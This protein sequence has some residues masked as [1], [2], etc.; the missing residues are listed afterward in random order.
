MIA[1]QV[2]VSRFVGW[3]PASGSAL[4]AWSLRGMLSLPLSAP[5]PLACTGSLS[6]KKNPKPKKMYRQQASTG[7]DAPHLISPGKRQIGPAKIPNPTAPDPGGDGNI[8]KSR[9][10][11]VGRPHGTAAP[12]DSSAGSS[13]TKHTLA[14]RPTSHAPWYL[15]QRVENFCPHKNLRSDV[16][17][18]LFI[19]AKN[20]EAT[21]KSF[22][23]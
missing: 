17:T 14:I 13:E 21:K 16:C 23:R 6:R 18:A 8:G 19:I 9:L 22:R 15:P 12:Q 10:S 5:P 2:T 20:L 11:P 7:K 3:R 4:M 1:A